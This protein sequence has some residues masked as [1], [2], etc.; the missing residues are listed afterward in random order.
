M[1]GIGF[2]LRALGARDN[3]LAPVASI[4]HAAAIAAGPWLFTV[5]ALQLIAILTAARLPPSVLDGFRLAVIYAFAL[6][7]IV[8]AP[9]ALVAARLV[10]D[11]LYARD[12]ARIRPVFLAASALSAAASFATALLALL[13]AYGVPAAT[14]IPTAS[15]SAIGAL[16]WV[17][18]AL[19]GAVRDYRSITQGFVR[20]LGVAVVAVVVAARWSGEATAMIWA[21]NAG[22]LI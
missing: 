16:I 4:G 18:L 6:S 3:L 15:C 12:V 10:G 19:C 1:A 17:A 21:F 5:A 2:G 9:F 22:L 13:V 8:S 14:A 11:A 7:L 20:G